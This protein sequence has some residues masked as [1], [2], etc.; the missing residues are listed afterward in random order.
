MSRKIT[1]FAV[2][3][4]LIIGFVVC[5]ALGVYALNTRTTAGQVEKLKEFAAPLGFTPEAQLIQYKTCWDAFPTH[6]GEVLYYQSTLT[7][8][9]FQGKIDQVTTSQERPLDVNL[10]GLLDINLVTSHD[11]KI[12]KGNSN[13]QAPGGISLGYKWRLEERGENWVVT[14]YDI[15]KDGNVYTLDGQPIDGNIVTIMLLTK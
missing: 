9:E 7:R 13:S 15:S 14:F 2:I 12:E 6:C 4:F 8:E 10:A 3:S 1:I 5:G 11:L